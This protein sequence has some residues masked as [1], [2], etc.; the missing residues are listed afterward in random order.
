MSADAWLWGVVAGLLTFV[1]LTGIG[2][3]IWTVP[4]PAVQAVQLAHV[5]AGGAL[6][7]VGIVYVIVHIWATV[8]TIT[9]AG[10]IV[11]RT[12][13]YAVAILFAYIL[14]VLVANPSREVRVIANPVIGVGSL[15]TLGIVLRSF[16]RIARGAETRTAVLGAIALLFAALTAVAG[17]GVA[18]GFMLYNHGYDSP[19][20]AHGVLA[21]ITIALVSWHIGQARRTPGRTSGRYARTGSL[22]RVALSVAIVC[23]VIS[24]VAAT[25]LLNRLQPGQVDAEQLVPMDVDFAQRIPEACKQCHPEPEK[26]WMAS[27]HRFAANNPVFTT[28]V[29]RLATDRGPE[30]V[31]VCLGCHAPHARDPLKAPLA[32]VLSSEGYRE[33]VHCV[34]CH[35]TLPGP[36][37]G[38]GSLLAKPLS[39]DAFWFLTDRFETGGMFTTA[40]V[41]SRLDLHRAAFS[42]KSE[43][44][45][46]CLPCHVQT[47]T[48]MTGGRLTLAIQDQ[49]DSWAASSFATSGRDCA[50][51]HMPR[52]VSDSS[53]LVVDHRLRAASTYVAGVAAGEKGVDEVLTALRGGSSLPPPIFEDPPR[54]EPGD[55]I[56]LQV[57]RKRVGDHDNLVVT[58]QGTGRIGHS[59]PNAPSDLVQVWLALHVTNAA[60]AVVMDVGR[61]GPRGAPRL[62]HAFEDSHGEP[63][64]DHRLWAIERVVDH[65]HI[66]SDGTHE[67]TVELPGNVDGPLTVEAAWRYRRLDPGVAADLGESRN[68]LFPIADLARVRADNLTAAGASSSAANP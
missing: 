59:F 6:C 49:Y 1:A 47:L 68:W 61:D 17:A 12:A 40:L 60:G 65:G 62:G 36:G 3:L 52:Y 43:G 24:V 26:G 41:S 31:R 53:Y 7:A 44:S 28:L 10:R 34:S 27:T 5:V 67:Q 29:Q 51:C 9:A 42:T 20:T 4:P 30:A 35:R 13:G 33:G 11:P 63:I 39:N 50:S 16:I 38:D 32:E 56:S 46:V 14:V 18:L 23:T 45:R 8:R 19:R 37:H 21:V 22:V 48:A 25:R 55:L 54:P 57:A 58:T 2:T 64:H 15:L 66:P